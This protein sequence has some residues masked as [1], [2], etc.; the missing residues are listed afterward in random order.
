MA[1]DHFGPQIVQAHGG[2][3]FFEETKDPGYRNPEPDQPGY[4]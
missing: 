4:L 1:S 3:P 2:K